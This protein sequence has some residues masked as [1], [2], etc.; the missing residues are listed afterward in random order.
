MGNTVVKE[1]YM[2]F[3]LMG[4]TG[5]IILSFQP[6]EFQNKPELKIN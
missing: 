3:V 1:K 2:G 5:Q 4:F 6:K